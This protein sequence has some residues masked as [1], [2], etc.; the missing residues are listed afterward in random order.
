MPVFTLFK[1]FVRWVYISLVAVSALFIY[2]YMMGLVTG[3]LSN[4][5]APGIVLLICLFFPIVQLIAAKCAETPET[6]NFKAKW[7]EFLGVFRLFALGVL[8]AI[9]STGVTLIYIGSF[10]VMIGYAVGYSLLFKF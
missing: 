7:V 2:K 6:E 5:I 3:L 8:V 1:G 9:Q 10:I 4:L